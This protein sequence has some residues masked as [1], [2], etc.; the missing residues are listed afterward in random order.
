MKLG[1]KERIGSEVVKRYYVPKTLQ[2]SKGQI[3]LAEFRE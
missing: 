2:Q 1:S 3:G